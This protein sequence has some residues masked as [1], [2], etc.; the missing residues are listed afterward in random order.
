M[1]LKSCTGSIL[2][3]Y[4]VR[5]YNSTLDADGRGEK[6][7]KTRQNESTYKWKAVKSS[8]KWWIRHHIFTWGEKYDFFY[9]FSEM[10]DVS[11]DK[12]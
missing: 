3:K 10:S 12:T 6:I 9:Q 7:K 4:V 11:K 2:K 1:K 5:S 8:K